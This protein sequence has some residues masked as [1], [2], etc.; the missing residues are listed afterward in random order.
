MKAICVVAENEVNPFWGIVTFDE[1][2]LSP[3]EAI[4]KNFKDS[5]SIPPGD[6]YEEWFG[7]ILGDYKFFYI[8]LVVGQRL[9]SI[10]YPSIDRALEI[11]LTD[12]DE[13]AHTCME[14]LMVRV[15]RTFDI[16]KL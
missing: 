15:C 2:E 10:E 11:G 12:A 1:N 4:E 14:Q 8:P 6:T 9:K 16:Q 3:D 13:I 7:H 5:V